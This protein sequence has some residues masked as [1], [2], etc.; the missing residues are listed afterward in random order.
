M[1]R[2]RAGCVFGRRN[3]A[4]MVGTAA[5]VLVISTTPMVAGNM[6]TTAWIQKQGRSYWAVKWCQ[7]DHQQYLLAS[8]PRPNIG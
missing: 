3:V 4:M 8:E 6:A 5:H 2:N 1:I 7:L